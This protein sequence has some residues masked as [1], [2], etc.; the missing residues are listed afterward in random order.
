MTKGDNVTD[1]SMTNKGVVITLSQTSM[2]E[3]FCEKSLRLL[4]IV[5]L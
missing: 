3:P 5:D 2:M 4:A 1:D